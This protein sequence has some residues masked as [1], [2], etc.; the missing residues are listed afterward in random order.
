MMFFMGGPQLGELE[1]G[2]LAAVVGA[3]VSVVIGGLGSF[4]CAAIAAVKS[5]SLMNFEIKP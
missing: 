2:S 4:V 5:K 1:A 3:P